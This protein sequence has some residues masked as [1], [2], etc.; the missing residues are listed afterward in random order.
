[1]REERHVGLRVKCVLLLSDFNQKKWNVSINCSKTS[2]VKISSACIELLH[3]ARWTEKRDVEKL[4][5]T[6]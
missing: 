2:N 1:M 3:A 6:Y 5:K 4:I